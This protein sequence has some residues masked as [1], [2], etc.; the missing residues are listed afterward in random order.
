MRQL[1]KNIPDHPQSRIATVP[2]GYADG[3][4]RLMSNKGQM[5]VNGEFAPVVGRICMDQC[6][7][8]VTDLEHEVHVG[9]GS[10]YSAGRTGH[11][12]ASTR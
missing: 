12:S 4:T 1:R 6:M 7:L 9:D 3:Y 2:I 8:D 5:L 10:S 11:A